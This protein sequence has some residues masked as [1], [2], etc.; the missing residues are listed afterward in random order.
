MK[1][2]IAYYILHKYMTDSDRESS[3]QQYGWEITFL[4]KER[5]LITFLTPNR[6]G[7]RLPQ[8]SYLRTLKKF[9]SEKS[10]KRCKKSGKHRIKSGNWEILRRLIFFL[11]P[12]LPKYITWHIIINNYNNNNW[13]NLNYA[14]DIKKTP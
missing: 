3:A 9:V 8:R 14:L 12:R 1:E 10:G 11:Y 5:T 13:L 4:Y 7:F 2:K 6:R